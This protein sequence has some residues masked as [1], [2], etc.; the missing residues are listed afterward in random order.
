MPTIPFANLAE[1]RTYAAQYQRC[2]KAVCYVFL[3]P[4]RSHLLV[5]DHLPNLPVKEGG[6]GVQVPA[7]GVE[8][9]ETPAEA[10]VR[11]LWEESGLS[12]SRPEYLCSYRW[13]V[14]LPHR[15]TR[16]VCHAYAFTAPA[17]TPKQWQKHADGHL[18]AFRWVEAL[19]KVPNELGLDWEL[20]AGLLHARRP[21]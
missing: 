7:G 21:Y 18:F 10:A 6:A 19:G 3:G 11:E 17:D 1:A 20:E 8:A 15:F 12:L 2:E 4:T 13:E 16:Q 5:F 14:Q 9:G